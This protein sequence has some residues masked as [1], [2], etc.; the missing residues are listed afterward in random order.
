MRIVLTLLLAVLLAG[1]CHA[2][3]LMGDEDETLEMEKVFRK[4]FPQTKGIRSL[5]PTSIEGLFEIKTEKNRF[6]FIP[7]HKAL[8]FG[9]IKELSK[10]KIKE[11]ALHK[12]RFKGIN[13]FVMKGDRVFVTDS[14]ILMI[15]EFWLDG[16]LLESVVPEQTAL[17][18]VNKEK[19]Q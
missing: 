6:Y 5:S 16:K 14:G 1:E 13:E 17:D 19:T 18:G 7:E 10:I 15:G 8:F 9:T 4:A 2:W 11:A 12:T 3:S